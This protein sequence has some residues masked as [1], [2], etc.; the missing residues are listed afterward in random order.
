M[1]C[2]FLEETHEVNKVL[3]CHLLCSRQVV[4]YTGERKLEDLMK[5]LDREMEK[6]KKDR[7]VVNHVLYGSVQ[8]D[9]TV[10]F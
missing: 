8:H 9:C 7:A 6:A 5:F 10:S 2:M 1:L 3:K 4:L